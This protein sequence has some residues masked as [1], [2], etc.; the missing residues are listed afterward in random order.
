MKKYLIWKTLNLSTDADNMIFFFR[1]AYFFL[2]GGVYKN[3]MG[4]SKIIMHHGEAGQGHSIYLIPH[5]LHILNPEK[6]SY[7]EMK[8]RLL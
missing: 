3:L 4:G 8:L 6:E 1:F 2:R 7:F 5:D